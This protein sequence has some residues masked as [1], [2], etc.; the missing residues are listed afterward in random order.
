MQRHADTEEG[1]K[2][3]VKKPASGSGG[4]GGGHGIPEGE[5]LGTL[6]LVGLVPLPLS[7]PQG[8]VAT[9]VSLQS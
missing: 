7:H 8:S 5:L 9:L 1:K 2:E 3:E 6:S 4:G